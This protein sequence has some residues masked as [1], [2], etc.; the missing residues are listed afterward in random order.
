MPWALILMV[1]GVTV[2]IALLEKTGGLDFFTAMLAR[3]ATRE[4]ITGAVAFVTGHH[5]RVQQHVRCRAPRLPPD[6]PWPGRTARRRRS[7]GHRHVDERRR[8]SRGHV[9]ALDDWRHVPR[10]TRTRPKSVRPITDC[11]RGDYR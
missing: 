4:T 10:R 11:S 7:P 6:D 9:A 3:T 5:L 1:T 2:L 8:S